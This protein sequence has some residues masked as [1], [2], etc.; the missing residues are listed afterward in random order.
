MAEYSPLDVSHCEK[1][2]D[3]S[4]ILFSDHTCSVSAFSTLTS[5]LRPTGWSIQTT[6][7]G[8]TPLPAELISDS[9]SGSRLTLMAPP[10]P[11]STAPTRSP[12][13]SSRTT[14]P[15]ASGGTA[16][17]FSPWTGGSHRTAQGKR[18]T[19]TARMQVCQRIW[20]Y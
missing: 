3:F 8:T 20:V 13:A 14:P 4:N 15:T 19:V 12:W 9:G 18:D 1:L 11:T 5:P 6:S 7:S 2:R 17:G 10:S 16:S